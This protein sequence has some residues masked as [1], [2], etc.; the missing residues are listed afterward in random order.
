MPRKIE[1]FLLKGPAGA[2][3]ALLEEPEEEEPREACLVCHPHP[4]YG[5]TLHNKVVHRMA[6]ALR[7]SGAAVLRFNFRGAGSSRGKHAGYAGGVQDAR[8]ALEWVRGRYPELPYS[9]AGFSFGAGVILTLGCGLEDAG[10]LL[11]AGLPTR[12]DAVPGLERCFTPKVFIQSTNDEYGPKHEL[13]AVYSRAGEPKTL[14][15]VAAKD[16][17]FNGAL[18]QFEETVRGA[19]LSTAL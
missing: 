7:H 13:E 6:R 17:F 4:L 9:L 5:G 18:D 10:L 11:A 2:L 1:S 14:L 8:A 19:R 16:H 12:G 3:E 15:W